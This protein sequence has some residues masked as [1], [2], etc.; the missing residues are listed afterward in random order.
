[1]GSK[2]EKK[3]RESSG[4]EDGNRGES[5]GPGPGS[6]TAVHCAFCRK[7]AGTRDH[8]LFLDAIADLIPPKYYLGARDNE[9]AAVPRKFLKKSARAEAKAQIKASEPMDGLGLRASCSR[10][11][12]QAERP[13]D[14]DTPRARWR[15]CKAAAKP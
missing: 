8:G 12:G 4:G 9:D 14:D 13:R 10:G 6:A 2:K 11:A 7:P 5:A 3:K 15:P 1:M